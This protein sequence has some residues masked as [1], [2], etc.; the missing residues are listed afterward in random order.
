MLVDKYVAAKL[1]WFPLWPLPLHFLF[2]A[3]GTVLPSVPIPLL[4]NAAAERHRYPNVCT[5]AGIHPLFEMQRF[6]PVAA[7]LCDIS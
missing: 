7:S 1:L 4:P 2:S 6:N 3:S 5:V